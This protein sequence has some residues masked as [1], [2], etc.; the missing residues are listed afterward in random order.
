MIALRLDRVGF[1]QKMRNALDQA[2]NPEAIL[3]AA[4]R[5][6][7]KELR[8][9]FLKKDRD[10]PNKL[11][12]KR[13]FFWNKI[14]HAVNVPVVDVAGRKATILIQSAYIAQKVFGGDITAKRKKN[15]SIPIS[16]EAY[17]LAP[18]VFE[19]QTGLKL[20]FVKQGDKAFLATRVDLKSKG[21]QVEYLLTPRV[22][23]EPDPTALP[24]E[25]QLEQAAVTAA[26]TALQKQL[27]K[28]I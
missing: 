16:P 4:G 21:L 3:Y 11:G 9:H 10:E 8:G 13:T 14:A 24:P 5:A 22:H 12:G 7:A 2:R 20:I 25:E 27:N 23:Q 19:Q 15:L 28:K 17:G 26:D 6:T 1:E 18:S